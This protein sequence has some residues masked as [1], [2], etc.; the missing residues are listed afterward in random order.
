MFDTLRNFGNAV[1]IALGR[2]V[3]GDVTKTR[4]G[5]E[6]HGAIDS[7]YALHEP[8]T[9]KVVYFDTVAGDDGSGDGTFG[10]PYKTYATAK[11][12][13]DGVSKT[14]TQ[15]LN[16][17]VITESAIDEPLQAASGLV[18]QL[19]AGGGDPFT[20][21]ISDDTNW[22]VARQ[23]NNARSIIFGEDERLLL[24]TAEAPQKFIYT[25][26]E[27]SNWTG[28]SDSAGGYLGSVRPIAFDGV[29]TLARVSGNP[30]NPYLI[31]EKSTDNGDNWS[32]EAS[33][34]Q[35]QLQV[36]GWNA[37][38]SQGPLAEARI[39]YLDST[40]VV[41][42]GAANDSI[43]GTSSDLV[44]WNFYHQTNIPFALQSVV[45]GLQI[46]AT[47]VPGRW[48][49]TGP[50]GSQGSVYLTTNYGQSW[51]ADA[52]LGASYILFLAPLRTSTGRIMMAAQRND[53]A[54]VYIYS[55]DSGMNWSE[56]TIPGFT[57]PFWASVGQHPN[58]TII[59][60]L[61]VGADLEWATSTDDGDSFVQRSD[62]AGVNIL[63]VQP[64][65]SADENLA[66]LSQ[67]DDQVIFFRE[68]SVGTVAITEVLQGFEVIGQSTVA[69]PVKNCTFSQK[70]TQLAG[71]NFLDCL[72][73]FNMLTTQQSQGS[74]PEDILA[75]NSEFRG[76]DQAYGN[77]IGTF[78]TVRRTSSGTA[79]RGKSPQLQRC[80]IVAEDGDA[81]EVVIEDLSAQY[82]RV[83]M[84][85]Q[86]G[87]KSFRPVM[88]GVDYV[89]NLC[90]LK[91]DVDLVDGGAPTGT[92][93]LSDTW[94]EGN[95]IT[96]A[97]PDLEFLSGNWRG[98]ASGNVTKDETKV[99][100]YFPLFRD[101]VDYQLKSQV[102]GDNV[103]SRL[104]EL[105]QFNNHGGGTPQDV[106]P[107][108]VLRENIEEVYDHNIV[109]PMP[110]KNDGISFRYP[111]DSVELDAVS[112]AL[113]VYYNPDK[114]QQQI[115]LRYE[116]LTPDMVAKIEF[117]LDF[118]DTRVLLGLDS[119][120]NTFATNVVADG[121][122]PVGAPYIDID[123]ASVPPG[124]FFDWQ[125]FK[126]H[127]L[128]ASPEPS[129]ATRLVLSQDLR[130]E[131]PD[132][133]AIKLS[134][135]SGQGKYKFSPGTLSGTR[136]VSPAVGYVSGAVLKFIRNLRKQE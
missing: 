72:V 50:S 36:S 43:V 15:M 119:Q 103:D 77:L 34:T 99:F 6:D 83:L 133:Q 54:R 24:G 17:A 125:G 122:Q 66:F 62:I 60:V 28:F 90:G 76:I 48:Y 33:F 52:A 56:G 78:I 73:N 114:T 45:N 67:S 70:V 18:P 7:G 16:Q 107:W 98:V 111:T 105:A 61:N 53:S 12:D 134:S 51:S 40:W 39:F 65:A 37:G 2:R 38:G 127:V 115:E 55:D 135:P 35:A 81:V 132:D 29:D 97:V 123:E 57:L 121:V 82:F 108:E 69:T 14:A 9:G 117:L 118:A 71:N 130:H 126:Y 110:G 129:G 88:N 85:S 106:G 27:G 109:L 120:F 92:V 20:N 124:V 47:K 25:E 96:G 44:N 74:P 79:Y 46:I 30:S 95:I 63:P 102:E 128:R 19:D 21:I 13:V 22:P 89:L 26:D 11:A 112:G 32:T 104:I 8:D 1:S 93:Q 23:G 100:A 58:G 131:I 3:T 75:T 113:D 10:N 116:T 101:L 4:I 80:K 84:A 86:S 94:V 68:S 49:M 136:P 41:I 59:A 87:G 5:A 64:T 91:G 31:I 42:G